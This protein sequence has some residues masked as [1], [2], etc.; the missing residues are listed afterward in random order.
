MNT[1]SDTLEDEVEP[2]LLRSELILR[3]SR[4]RMATAKGFMHLNLAPPRRAQGELF[5]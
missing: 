2:F 4:G 5:E 1:S 3:T